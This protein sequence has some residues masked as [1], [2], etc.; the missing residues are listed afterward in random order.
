[1]TLNGVITIILHY[2]AEFGN[3]RIR[4]DPLITSKVTRPIITPKVEFWKHSISILLNLYSTRLHL[5]R[6]RAVTN[7]AHDVLFR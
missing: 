4:P 2:I 7:K 5:N 3:F 6:R 1:M